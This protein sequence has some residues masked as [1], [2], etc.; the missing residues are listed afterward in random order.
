MQMELII[1]VDDSVKTVHKVNWNLNRQSQHRLFMLAENGC[2]LLCKA[3]IG[4]THLQRYF[5]ESKSVTCSLSFKVTQR[6]FQQRCR[7]DQLK[8]YYSYTPP[9]LRNLLVFSKMNNSI[10]TYQKVFEIQHNHWFPSL[11]LHMTTKESAVSPFHATIF[12][13]NLLVSFTIR[14]TYLKKGQKKRTVKYF[15]T[16]NILHKVVLFILSQEPL[17]FKINTQQYKTTNIRRKI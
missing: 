7:L 10:H 3:Y 12:H 8:R 2:Q 1:P 14:D 6:K 13:L 16:F 11:K 9:F 17:S 4:F 5:T 15:G